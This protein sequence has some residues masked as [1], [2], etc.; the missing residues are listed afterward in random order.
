MVNHD[1]NHYNN[2]GLSGEFQLLMS[3]LDVFGRQLTRGVSSN[4]DNIFQCI[5]DSI[6][7]AIDSVLKA[8][9]EVETVREQMWSLC[10]KHFKVPT[11]LCKWALNEVDAVNKALLPSEPSAPVEPIAPTAPSKDQPSLFS[12]D[13]L[14]H[15]GLCCQAVS[16]CNAGTF[17]KFFDNQVTNHLLQ[18]VSMSISS[19]KKNVDRYII[20]KQGNVIYVAFESEPTLSQWMDSMYTSFEDGEYYN[21]MY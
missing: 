4:S 2:T 19:E 14:H 6:H 5:K 10:Y 13:T 3:D 7:H 12:K 9:E 15:A 8:G 16:T 21:I 1:G 17:M 18:E 11:D 20:A